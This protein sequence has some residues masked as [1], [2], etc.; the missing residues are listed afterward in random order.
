MASL[1][2]NSEVRMQNSDSVLTAPTH[3][4]VQRFGRGSWKRAVS[5]FCILHSAFLLAACGTEAENTP[6]AE[7]AVAVRIGTENV[8]TVQRDTIVV[9]PAISGELRAQR[10]ATVR[11]EIG[12]SLT[13]VTVEEGQAV[14]RG[15]LLGRIETRTLD[16][17][18]QSA[19]SALRSAEN[20]LAVAQRE[21]ER[22]ETLVKAGALAARDLDVARNNVSS[23]EAQLAD[24]KSRL[25]SAERQLG[26]T[27]LRAPIDGIVSRRAVNAGDVVSVGAE[28]F[29]IIDPSS[30]RLEASVPSDDLSRLRIGS[31]VEFT[32]RGYEQRFQGRIER[33]APQADPAT[34]QV[35]MFVT[36]PNDGGRLVAG[37]F[38][39]GRVVSESADGL[40]VPINAVNTSGASPW[41]LRVTNGKAEQVS[42]S[43][44]LTDPRTERV[45]VTSGL[46]EGDMLLRGAAQGITPGTPVQVDG[47]K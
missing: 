38:A 30:M 42:V 14:R 18:R 8:V 15:V 44:G 24:A 36:I 43:L 9:G 31:L 19:Q 5:A 11:A 35:S 37:L 47:A 26:D 33:I 12:G 2:D 13:Q 34:R 46:N 45:Q 4:T 20:Q 23:A 40:V 39:E 3:I 10:E 27:V 29:T 25:A 22:A 1:S 6:E 28:L 32:V 17:V 21:M 7:P 16:D 41:V